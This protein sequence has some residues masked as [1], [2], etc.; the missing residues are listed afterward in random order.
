MSRTPAQRVTVSV[1]GKLILA[2][3]YDV[4]KGGTALAATVAP[5]LTVTLAL[6]DG[7][8]GATHISSDLWT[9]P[10]YLRRDDPVSFYGHDEMLTAAVAVAL[11]TWNLPD[12]N[13]SVQSGFDVSSGFG[14]SSA[15]RLAV[16]AAGKLLAHPDLNPSNTRESMKESMLDCA[17]LAYSLQKAAQSG[18]SGYDIATQWLGGAVEFRCDTH[19][20]SDRWPLQADTLPLSALN[21][22]NENIHVFVGGAGAPTGKMMQSTMR[23]L[24]EAGSPDP[25]ATCG[26]P[27][28]SSIQRWDIL[29]VLSRNLVDAMRTLM[30]SDDHGNGQAIAAAAQLR[31]F[32]SNSPAFPQK[33]ADTL[34]GVSGLD[35]VWS[36]KTTGAG[37]EDAIFLIGTKT[38]TREAKMKL[39]NSG[40]RHLENLFSEKSMCVDEVVNHKLLH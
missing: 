8:Q 38:N 14:S 18:A 1:P 33:V 5:R 26:L 19:A 29:R 13:V 4:L 27:A 21:Q 25:L 23:W 9:A 32:F 30:A 34:A 6:A 22:L 7:H 15:L 16:L 39:I 20:S 10:R 3:E 11:K 17:R 36:W 31:R 37:G 2:G 35:R 40:W 12:L 24:D 28:D